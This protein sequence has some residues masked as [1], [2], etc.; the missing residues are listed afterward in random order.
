V[1][2]APLSFAYF[3]ILAEVA[4]AVSCDFFRLA[5]RSFL[6]SQCSNVE[7]AAVGMKVGQAMRR[8][9]YRL[10]PA[11]K[12][13]PTRAV[14]ASMRW[15]LIH[16]TRR[17]LASAEAKP[18]IHSFTSHTLHSSFRLPGT[19]K[20]GGKDCGRRK[21]ST[22]MLFPCG[23]RF[24]SVP[25]ARSFAGYPPMRWM[26]RG[27]TPLPPH[28]LISL[29]KLTGSITDPPNAHQSAGP[30]PA[31]SHV[32]VG[33][34]CRSHVSDACPGA[35]GTSP[36]PTLARQADAADNARLRSRADNRPAARKR[37]QPVNVATGGDGFSSELS[38]LPP[39]FGPQPPSLQ[40]SSG[41]LD[42]RPGQH[43]RLGRPQ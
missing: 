29:G 18:S 2:I 25:S 22:L 27:R 35:L 16:A 3:L 30:S 7:E 6:A 8:L 12:R 23:L 28:A 24:G 9:Q 15:E 1:F 20:R 43:A 10:S 31:S 19:K 42:H 14:P 37:T 36:P 33:R 34:I 40:Q 11:A 32:S 39:P 38:A 5:R 17:R 13:A 41:G 26:A 21:Q 4:C